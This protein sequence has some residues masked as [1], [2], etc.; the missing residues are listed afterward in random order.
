M[1]SL[2]KIITDILVGTVVG[3]I[4]SFS[5]KL[6]TIVWFFLVVMML[7]FSF[8]E[9]AEAVYGG[10]TWW[11]LLDMLFMIAGFFLGSFMYKQGFP[12]EVKK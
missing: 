10:I 11:I 12:K 2:T 8:M 6:S 5:K 4:D 3:G 1:I 7:I 9:D